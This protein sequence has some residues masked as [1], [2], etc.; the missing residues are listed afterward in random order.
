MNND[1]ANVIRRN[2]CNPERNLE[3]IKHFM[4]LDNIE[5]IPFLVSTNK[6]VDEVNREY[7]YNYCKIYNIK[8]C[9]IN[10][11]R[12]SPLFIADDIYSGNYT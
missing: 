1:D 10:A 6:E 12:G 11:E 3:K 2:K 5:N 9:K 4:S 8:D 7:I